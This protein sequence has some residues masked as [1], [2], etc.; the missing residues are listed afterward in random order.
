M[1]IEKKKKKIVILGGGFGGIYTFKKL[2]KLV[3]Y[4]EVSITIVDRT[5][6]FLFTPL[7]HEVATGGLTPDHVVESIR[8]IIR[9]SKANFC[10]ANIG[11]IN[12]D[13]KK[14]VLDKAV[15]DYDYLVIALGSRTNTYGISGVEDYCFSLKDLGDAVK[16]RNRFIEVFEKAS[17]EKDK[18]KRQKLLS[19]AVIGGGPTGVELIGE[20]AEF[21]FDSLNKLF[22]NIICEKEVSINLINRGEDL[23][24]QFSEKT[25]KKAIEVLEGKGIKVR[26]NS[27]VSEVRKDGVMLINGKKVQVETV[28][29]T[30]GVIP[31][32]PE[33]NEEVELSETN[34]IMVDTYLRMNGKSDVFVIGDISN[35]KNLNGNIMPMLAQVASAQGGVVAENIFAKMHGKKMR[36]YDYKLKGLLISIGQWM[37]LGE[38]KGVRLSGRFMWWVWR[39]IY[40]TKFASIS[41]RVKIAID[42]TVDLFYP[43]DTAKC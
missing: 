2:N 27:G 6:Y 29:W 41:K 3:D 43:R 19:F 42:W 21:F 16:L 5:N 24:S 4:D 7:L 30:A 31:N 18:I 9:K 28:I 17:M 11:K 36:K 10:L 26:L 34:R 1:E 39:T 8:S 25:R 22:P 38:I 37:A 33:F 32:I 35:S 23:I 14:I 15:I 20:M 12:L 40:L 13:E